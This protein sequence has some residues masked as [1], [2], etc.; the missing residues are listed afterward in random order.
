MAFRTGSP[1]EM[2]VVAAISALAYSLWDGTGNPLAGL[3][4]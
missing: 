3:F 1:V 4:P 2:V